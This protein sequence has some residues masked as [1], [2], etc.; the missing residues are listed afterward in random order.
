MKA[1]NI[2]SLFI[3][4]IPV[5]QESCESDQLCELNCNNL[6]DEDGGYPKG[7]GSFD[8]KFVVNF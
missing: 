8:P 7:V 6:Y 2:K 4:L 1:N 3:S 5:N